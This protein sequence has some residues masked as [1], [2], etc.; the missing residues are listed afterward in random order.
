MYL[1]CSKTRIRKEY[2]ISKKLLVLLFSIYM[3]VGFL[4]LLVYYLGTGNY[5]TIYIYNGNNLTYLCAQ[6]PVCYVFLARLTV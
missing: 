1:F 5:D 4:F 6:H 3:I 2:D